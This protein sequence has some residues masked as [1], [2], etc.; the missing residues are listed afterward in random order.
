MKERVLLPPEIAGAIEHRANDAG[1]S[2]DEMGARLLAQGALLVL[3]DLLA[4]L[5]DDPPK[6]TT[7]RPEPGAVSESAKTS[8]GASVA[9]PAPEP[10]AARRARPSAG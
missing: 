6:T 2:F 8:P 4:P 5:L 1:L 9:G 7:P 3:Q 10:G